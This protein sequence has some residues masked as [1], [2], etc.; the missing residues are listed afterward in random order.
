LPRP[1]GA[2]WHRQLTLSRS[3][4]QLLEEKLVACN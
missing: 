3:E 4:Q 2:A 1:V